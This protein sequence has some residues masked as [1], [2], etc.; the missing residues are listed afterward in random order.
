V[1]SLLAAE[2]QDP[3]AGMITV[4]DVRV[5]KDLSQARIFVSVF[6]EDQA[7]T[8]VAHLNKSAGLFRSRLAKLLK[9][10]VTP[11]IRFIYDDTQ[12][13]GSRINNILRDVSNNAKK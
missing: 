6:N 3:S 2:Y 10:R 12:L 13:Q 9:A 4:V 5:T 1:A 7:K 8:A 11:A